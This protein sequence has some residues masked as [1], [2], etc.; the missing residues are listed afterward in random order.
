MLTIYGLN[1]LW[2]D[3]N[4]DAEA[5]ANL[6]FGQYVYNQCKYETDA[7]YHIVDPKAAFNNLSAHIQ[8]MESK[9]E[10]NKQNL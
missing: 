7:S 1:E 5:K 2:K 9:H 4:A 6:R 10:S 3:W 8:Y